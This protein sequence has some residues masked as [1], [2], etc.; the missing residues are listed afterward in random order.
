MTPE[1]AEAYEQACKLCRSPVTCDPDRVCKRMF[2]AGAEHGTK[3]EREQLI[4]LLMEQKWPTPG[5][6]A[7]CSRVIRLIE[8]RGGKA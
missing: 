4:A 5:E 3:T 7:A 6:L 1:M 8:G 2:A